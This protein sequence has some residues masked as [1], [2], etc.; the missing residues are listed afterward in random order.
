MI[1]VTATMHVP[2]EDIVTE[3]RSVALAPGIR[4]AVEKLM[5]EAD[6]STEAD[7]WTSVTIT[8]EREG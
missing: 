4:L 2:G 7:A 3:A 6:F 5:A 8:A 1:R